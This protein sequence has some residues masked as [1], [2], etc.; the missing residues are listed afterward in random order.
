MFKR[1]QLVRNI[2]LNAYIIGLAVGAVS[3]VAWTI[4]GPVAFVSLLVFLFASWFSVST[5]NQ[6]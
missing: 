3:G 2:L 5:W 6:V 1:M 4:Y